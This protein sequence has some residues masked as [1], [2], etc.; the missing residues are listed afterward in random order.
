MRRFTS[1]SK[2]W[3]GLAVV[4]GAGVLLAACSAENNGQNSLRPKGPA[5]QKIDHLFTPLS[6]IA[7]V[8][9]VLVHSAGAVFAVRYRYEPAKTEKPT[10]I[11]G[12][13]TLDSGSTAVH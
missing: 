1:R 7:A 13:T 2:R 10:Q 6:F 9:G 8:A 5:A 12:S 11:T 3:V 4:A